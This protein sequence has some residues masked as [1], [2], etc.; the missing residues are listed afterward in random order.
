MDK[1]RA[2]QILESLI[3]DAHELPEM[4]RKSPDLY[5]W[6]RDAKLA[7]TN[8]FGTDT[9]HVDEFET[10]PFSS[11]DQYAYEMDHQA[12]Y[13]D[14]VARAAALLRSM[15]EEIDHYW[16]SS[17]PDTKHTSSASPVPNDATKVFIVHGR[18]TELLEQLC[19]Y[20]NSIGL[21]PVEWNQAIAKTQKGT[22]NIA[23]ILDAAFSE[24]QAVIVLLTGDDEAKLRH[25]FLKGDDPPYEQKLTPQ[26]RPNVLF[27]SGMAMGRYPS[28]TVLVQIGGH[29]PFSDI[30]GKH[31]THLDNTAEKRQE[32]ATKLS[33]AGCKVD[34]SGTRWLKAG[35]LDQEAS[36]QYD[37][38]Q[39]NRFSAWA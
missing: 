7:L 11:S 25:E 35:N 2:K 14:G 30:A 5:K 37:K 33:N 1:E 16:T 36:Y 15:V 32:L 21:S 19:S 8:I 4:G 10:I 23:E 38:Q 13:L 39:D 26:S 34:I 27:E 17:T 12:A 31:I 20:L 29:R 6:R 22:P 24:A 3:G 9:E 28:R 18:D